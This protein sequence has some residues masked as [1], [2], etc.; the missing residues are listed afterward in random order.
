MSWNRPLSSDDP[1]ATWT[2]CARKALQLANQEAHRL[3]SSQVGTEH[4][5]LGLVKDGDGVASQVF[6]Q[7]GVNLAKTRDAVS[8][9][10]G[11]T[12]ETAAIGSL[13]RRADLEQT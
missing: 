7:L 1:H 9:V 5:L 3:G 8:G 12:A 4:L 13:P 10:G 11:E 2:C 6:R